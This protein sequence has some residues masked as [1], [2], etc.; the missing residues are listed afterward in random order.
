MQFLKRTAGGILAVIILV[1]A[2]LF[3]RQPKLLTE[4]NSW[5]INDSFDG[6]RSYA[7]LVYHVRHDS[8][9]AHYEGMNYP[10]GDKAAFTDN[11]PLIA[12]SVKFIS[13]HITDLSAYCCGI[14]NGFLMLSIVL[15]AVFIF[16]SFRNLKLP[17]WYAVPIAIGITM[18]SP[19]LLRL[20]AHYGLAHPFVVPLLFWMSLIFHKNKRWSFSLL[21]ALVLFLCAQ[22]HFYLFALGGSLV[23]GL[24]AF[25]TLFS[26]NKK[27][28]LI[29]GFHLL[30][31]VVLPLV[32][33]QVL[34][35]DSLPDRPSKPY[36]F[37]A[38][39]AIWESVFL[40]ADF[41]LGRWIHSKVHKNPVFQ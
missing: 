6:F 8:T 34:M 25:K 20:P 3:I 11:L 40:P 12:N 41:E 35:S 32:I 7:A 37:F 26:Y 39:K 28:L 13:T 10:Y 21:I 33:L 36:G 1:I 27:A 9:Y 18:L 15:C 30:I 19:Q 14:L 22:I 38:Y 24:L 17:S 4:P 16:L 31:Q 2:I 5:L 23:M 29:N